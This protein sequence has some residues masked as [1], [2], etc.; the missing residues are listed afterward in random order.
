MIYF[1]RHGL[2]EANVRKVFAGQRDN[3]LLTEKGRE[4]AFEVGKEILRQSLSIDR[5]V[6]SSSKRSFETAEIISRELNFDASKIIVDDRII[7]YDMGSLS[8]TPWGIISSAILVKAKGAE[9]PHVFCERVSS[10]S[11]ELIGL[12]GNTLLVSHGGVGRMLETIRENK[13]AELF[14]DMPIMLNASVIL[15]DWIK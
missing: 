8:G 4:Q 6:S 13:N 12:G 15:I 2:S 9:D 3:S 10:C 14:Y 5:I 1:V 7:E 11:K